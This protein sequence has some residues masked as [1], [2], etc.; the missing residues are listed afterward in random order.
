MLHNLLPSKQNN[1]NPKGHE[2]KCLQKRLSSP[3]SPPRATSR[4]K[5]ALQLLNSTV[6]A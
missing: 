4:T 3:M 1:K 5:E 6:G 2:D